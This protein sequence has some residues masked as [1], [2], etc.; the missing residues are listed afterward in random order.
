FNDL[1]RATMFACA[2][3]TEMSDD[4]LHALPFVVAFDLCSCA[5]YKACFRAPEVGAGGAVATHR[6]IWNQ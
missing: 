1:D 3:L 4:V 5:Y 2:Q 6:F